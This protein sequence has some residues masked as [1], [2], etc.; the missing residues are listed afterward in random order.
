MTMPID[1]ASTRSHR[2]LPVLVGIAW[3]GLY[4]HNLAD[5]PQL[6]PASPENSLP[7]LA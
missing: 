2:L 7:A 4:V 1:A 6:T 5:L 3:L